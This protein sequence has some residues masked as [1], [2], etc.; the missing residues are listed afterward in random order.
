MREEVEYVRSQFVVDTMEYLHK[1]GRCSSVAKLFASILKIK[2]I[3]VV[4]DGK[5]GVGEKARGKMEVCLDRLLEMVLQDKDNIDLSRVFITHSE[6]DS[7]CE[8][9][10]VKLKEALP[11]ANI[12]STRAGCIVST[13]CGQGTIGILYTLKH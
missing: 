8:Y 13:H 10:N 12:I 2:P 11:E 9:L 7:Y 4:R 3:I 1:G 5:M 6:A